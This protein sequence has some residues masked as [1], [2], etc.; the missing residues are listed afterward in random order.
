M[1]RYGA[2]SDKEIKPPHIFVCTP[3]YGGQCYGYY[4]QSVLTLQTTLKD[5]GISSTFSFMF[6]ESLI[7]RARNALTHGFLKSE[8]THLLFIDSDIRFNPND[9]VKMIDLSG[10]EEKDL[11]LV[12]FNPLPRPVADVVKVS[13]DTPREQD[14]WNFTIVDSE[15]N[16]VTVQEISRREKDYPVHDLDGRPWPYYTDQHLCYLD[17]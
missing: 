15:G 12:V 4:A 16:E 7:T 8:A 13:I 6:N 1:E 17:Y 3:M 9:V 14:I 5:A 11:L 10:Y 2:M